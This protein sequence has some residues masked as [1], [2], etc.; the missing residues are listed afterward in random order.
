MSH[1]TRV[2]GLK[3]RSVFGDDK[4]TLVAPHTGAWIETANVG[5][6]TF[7]ATSHPTRV[8]GL[9]LNLLL[10]H[11]TFNVAPHTG[12]WIETCDG[13]NY[14][15]RIDVAPHTGAWIETQS[16]SGKLTQCQVAP[17]TGAWIETLSL[18]TQLIA[19][20]SHPTRVRGLKPTSNP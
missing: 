19:A 5:I 2:R 12:A 4:A 15:A 11:P 10:I 13:I 17:H 16:Q 7:S 14:M 18:L 8:R 3:L 20:L 9:K 1:P 6:F